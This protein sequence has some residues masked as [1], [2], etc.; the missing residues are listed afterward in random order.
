MR[1]A[2]ITVGNARRHTGGYLYHARVFAGLRSQGFV[3]DQ[4]SASAALL[5]DQLAVAAAFGAR[6]D[7]QPYDVVVIDALARGVCGAWVA[8]W[9]A[10]RPVVVLVHQLPSVAEA[11]RAQIER[12]Q[13]LEAP[14]LEAD[15]VIAVS[16]HGRDMLIERGV[17]AARIAVVSPGFDRLPVEPAQ[18]PR[19][20]LPDEPLRVLCVAQWIVRKGITTL[21]TAWQQLAAVDA[22]LELIGETDADPD[23]ATHVEKL[24]AAIPAERVIVRGPVADDA[25][26]QAYRRADLFVLP[27]RFEG[28][29]MVYAE[30]LA[31]GL[32]IVAC[33]VGPVPAL[34]TPQAGMFVPPDDPPALAQA[35]DR[36][37]HDPSIRAR[38][39][40]GA[41][42]RAAALPRWADTTRRF[43]QAI[44]Q[45]S[46]G[47]GSRSA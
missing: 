19:E 38:L 26:Q 34:I 31:H 21:I 9:R 28:Y 13:A 14:L 42:Q 46:S 10:I 2:F 20:R 35:I 44:M 15:R 16:E 32:P 45:A 23:Y 43:G 41:R 22:V 30:A 7:P 4:I 27:S 12:E 39:A 17:P 6:F 24:L 33:N 40:S 3:I 1:L 25:L 29:G 47:S 37:L 11:E 8:R 18:V 5:E 36:L